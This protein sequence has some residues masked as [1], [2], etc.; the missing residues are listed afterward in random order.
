MVRESWNTGIGKSIPRQVARHKSNV[1]NHSAIFQKTKKLSEPGVVVLVRNGIHS[2]T[3]TIGLLAILLY[4]S[5]ENS[6][7]VGGVKKM[8]TVSSV[9]AT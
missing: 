4:K 7:S 5:M 1:I 2:P 8:A 9:W 3:N 6:V